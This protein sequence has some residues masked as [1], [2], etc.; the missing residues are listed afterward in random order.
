MMKNLGWFSSPRCRM[1]GCIFGLQYRLKGICVRRRNRWDVHVLLLHSGILLR[2]LSE[3]RESQR[4]RNSVSPCPFTNHP[5]FF[6]HLPQFIT[7]ASNLRWAAGVQRMSGKSMNLFRNEIVSLCH[8]VLWAFCPRCVFAGYCRCLVWRMLT[9]GHS[10]SLWVPD[11]AIVLLFKLWFYCIWS[12]G[13]FVGGLMDVRCFSTVF[14]CVSR[15][16]GRWIRFHFS[17]FLVF[18]PFCL[19]HLLLSSGGKSTEHHTQV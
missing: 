11:G 15:A 14:Y 9:R 8:F 10:H 13:I 4:Q 16:D 18:L 19:I 17:C 6:P 3:C 2:Q 7:R 5:S 12:C 1:L